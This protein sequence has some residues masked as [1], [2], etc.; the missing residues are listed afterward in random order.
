MALNAH[1][2]FSFFLPTM[3]ESIRVWLVYYAK[4]LALSSAS[5][6]VSVSVSPPLERIATPII[7]TEVIE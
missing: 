7:S 4:S 1:D 2:L 5:V 3:G 6:F